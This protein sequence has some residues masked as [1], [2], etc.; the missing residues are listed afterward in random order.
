MQ[1]VTRHHTRFLVI[2]V[3]FY[4]SLIIDISCFVDK[5]T[6]TDDVV[7]VPYAKS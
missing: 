6:P 7:S 5:E 2:G 3:F 4:C 1:K